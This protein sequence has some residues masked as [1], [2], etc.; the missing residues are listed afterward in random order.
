MGSHESV[1][2]MV[3]VRNVFSL[4]AANNTYQMRRFFGSAFDRL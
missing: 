3:Y 1:Y 4:F 2:D